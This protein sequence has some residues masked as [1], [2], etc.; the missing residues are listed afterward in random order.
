VQEKHAQAVGD[1]RCAVLTIDLN[2][3]SGAKIGARTLGDDINDA[4]DQGILN[5]RAKEKR[6]E[7]LGASLLGDPCV[8]RLCYI[9]AGVDVDPGK[10]ISPKTQRIFDI[11]HEMEDFIAGQQSDADGVFKAAA[12]RWFHDAGFDLRTHNSKG[13]QFRWTAVEGKMSGAVDG[14]ILSG[15]LP[16][17]IRYPV[18]WECKALGVKGWNKIKKHGVKVGS[19]TYYGQAQVNLG[20]LDGTS[21]SLFTAINK[22]DESLHHELIEF[23]PSRAQALSDRG[24]DVIRAVESGHLLDRCANHSDFFVCKMCS[25]AER[26]WK[27]DV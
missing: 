1:G 27:V 5:R 13:E 15:P 22:N 12:V 24:V 26:C 6:R 23:D 3:G 17:K 11:G 10:E 4:I 25:Y 9:Y 8:R 2:S 19:E 7:Y 14:V 20:Y 21:G 16:E 18:L